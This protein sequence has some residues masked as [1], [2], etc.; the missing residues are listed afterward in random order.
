MEGVQDVSPILSLR[1]LPL[2]EE[3]FSQLTNELALR[4]SEAMVP[5]VD[6]EDPV[7]NPTITLDLVRRPPLTTIALGCPPHD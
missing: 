7:L 3:T 5:F 1:A 2:P 4:P 6:Y